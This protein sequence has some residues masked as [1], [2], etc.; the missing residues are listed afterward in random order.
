MLKEI[1]KI[2]AILEQRRIYSES[3]LVLKAKR[4]WFYSVVKK[5]LINRI[6]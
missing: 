2:I 3:K 6:S 4:M 1:C 5:M